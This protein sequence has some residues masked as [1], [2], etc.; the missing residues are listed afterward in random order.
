MAIREDLLKHLQ[1]FKK[2]FTVDCI[3]SGIDKVRI[4]SE[5]D[6]V[7]DYEDFQSDLEELTT[8]LNKIPGSVKEVNAN[9]LE[10]IELIFFEEEFFNYFNKEIQSLAQNILAESKLLND[11]VKHNL[12]KADITENFHSLIALLNAMNSDYVSEVENFFSE[13]LHAG[14]LST[15]ELTKFAMLKKRLPS[16]SITDLFGAISQAINSLNVILIDSMPGNFANEWEISAIIQNSI[17]HCEKSKKHHLDNTENNN[18]NSSS[19]IAAMPFFAMSASPCK[20]RKNEHLQ[21]QNTGST[22]DSDEDLKLAIAL[23]LNSNANN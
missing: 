5:E 13:F 7:Y 23:S 10:S 16:G 18:N 11:Q 2:K 20:K 19:Q 4:N 6:D 15:E 22:S 21:S 9:F 14:T 17:R 3:E 12:F 1:E 8:I